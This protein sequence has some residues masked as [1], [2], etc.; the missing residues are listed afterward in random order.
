M[1]VP[2]EKAIIDRTDELISLISVIHSVSVNAP[3]ENIARN[4]K[5]PQR[6]FVVTMWMADAG[7]EGKR[8]EQ[9]LVMTNPDGKP[10]LSVLAEFDMTKQF[11]RTIGRINRFPVGVAGRYELSVSIREIGTEEW[12]QAGSYP[13][14]VEHRQQSGQPTH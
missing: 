2:C 12:S 14:A 1:F 3:D 7:D 4:P 10:E 6:W 11:H 5:I 13:I 9:R 8:F